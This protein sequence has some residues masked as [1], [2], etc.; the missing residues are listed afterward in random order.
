MPGGY[1]RSDQAKDTDNGQKRYSS[2]PLTALIT[3]A[4]CL[5][6]VKSPRNEEVRILKGEAAR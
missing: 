1:Q 3:G 5:M 2:A 4:F 6:K